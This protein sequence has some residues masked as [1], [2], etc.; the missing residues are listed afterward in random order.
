MLLI[1][2]LAPYPYRLLDFLVSFWFPIAYE[3]NM[4]SLCRQPFLVMCPLCVL[5]KL[6]VISVEP[7]WASATVACGFIRVLLVLLVYCIVT[8]TNFG[9]LP[10]LNC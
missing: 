5:P 10:Q 7:L 1:T 4:L 8:V 9:K 6:L 3:Q 2:F